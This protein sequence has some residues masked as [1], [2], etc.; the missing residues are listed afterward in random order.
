MNNESL[1]IDLF[2]SDEDHSTK[3][4][5]LR[6]E[7][8]KPIA[9][10][11]LAT[12]DKW[13][14]S[15]AMQK[16]I[17]R[18]AVGQTVGAAIRLHQVDP[19]YLRRRMPIIAL[20]DIGL[21]SA[22]VCRDVLTVCASSKWWGTDVIRTISFLASSMAS[23]VKSRAACDAYC[24]TEVHPDRSS[25]LP[26]LLTRDA[27]DLI[28]IAC[29]RLRPQIERLF[30][31]RV[32]GGITVNQNGAYRTLSRCDLPALENI[33]LNLGL[34]ETVCWLMAR[35]RKTAGLAAMLPIAF[36][37]AQNAVVRQ[38]SDFP[39]AMDS[40]AGL[41]LCTLDQYTQ[42]GKIALRRFYLSSEAL[43]DFALQHVPR[44]NP[45]PLI[46]LAMFQAE[47]SLLDRYLSSPQLDGLTDA[48]E[49]S[50]MRSMGMVEPTN[51]R[52]LYSLLDHEADRLAAI[53]IS[54]L[55]N[56]L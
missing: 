16:L 25:L 27:A 38:G 33:G 9:H 53:R 29:D 36:E 20:E 24:L 46:N 11:L 35:Q 8:H 44:H 56:L 30:A 37:A 17:R 34:P 19:T 42:P 21:G 26:Q 49:E 13:L 51:R 15:S 31:L 50:E 5:N 55:E 40:I 23:A 22:M 32:L 47:S 28:D 6:W 43:Q 39:R 41:P 3:A 7:L 45:Q 10:T 12:A 48:T 14:L 54:S 4:L 2:A 52:R 1:N 18:G